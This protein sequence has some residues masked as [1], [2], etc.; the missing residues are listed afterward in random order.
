MDTHTTHRFFIVLSFLVW[1]VGEARAADVAYGPP[2]RPIVLAESK[3]TQPQPEPSKSLDPGTVEDV[4]MEKGVLTMDDWIRIKA[5]EEYRLGER[6]RRVETLEGWKS[7]V[8]GLPILNDKVN[9]GLNALQWLY[10]HSDAKVPEGKSQDNISI[11]RSELIFWGKISEHLPRWH[12]LFE[13]QSINVTS[14]TPG[15]TASPCSGSASVPGSA[16]FFR[17]SY[18]DYRPVLAWA[19]DLN[20]FRLGI[21]RMPFGIFTETSGGLRDVISSPYLT[22]VGSGTGNRTGAAGTVDFLQERDFFV[23]ARGRLFN[24]LEYVAG[25]MNNNNFHANATGTNQPKAF[26]SRVRL[27][28]SESSSSWVS[29]TTIQGHSNNT[30]TNINGRGKGTFDRYGLDFRYASKWVPGFMIQG[31]WWQGHDGAN[32][33]TVGQPAQ[34]DCSNTAICGG[35]GAPGVNRRTWYLLAKYLI[36]DGLFKN[37]EPTV[38]Y[39]EFDPNTAV[40]NDVYTRTILGLTYYFENLPPKIQSKVQINYEFR[41]HQ[42]NGPGQTYNPATDAFGQNALLLQWQ[43]RY[44]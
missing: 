19:P 4:L 25:I 21:F 6:E 16:T 37:F 30:N 2:T 5:E 14:G 24:R 8:E 20:F 36:G 32:A 29:F 41:H 28:G 38:M 34:G 11:R 10:T 40:G 31:E 23:D 15:C 12:A 9:I 3:P 35:S 7:K 22:S 44:M 17:E 42:G 43:I 33:T 18:I 1:L 26:Y 27:L 13:F 39:E